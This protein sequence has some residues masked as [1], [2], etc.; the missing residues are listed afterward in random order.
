MKEKKKISRKNLAHLGIILGQLSH[1][2]PASVQGNRIYLLDGRI[3]N[4]WKEM[5]EKIINEE[6]N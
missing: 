1:L 3:Y 2:Q 6:I 4:D 5:I